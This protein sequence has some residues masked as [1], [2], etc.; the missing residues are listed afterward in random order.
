MLLLFACNKAGTGDHVALM[1]CF[2]RFDRVVNW[3]A[4]E[5]TEDPVIAHNFVGIELDVDSGLPADNLE[6]L[7]KLIESFKDKKK[8]SW[9][10]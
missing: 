3:V 9:G 8:V 1:Q 10:I 6:H 2:M 7:Q 4:H 5:K